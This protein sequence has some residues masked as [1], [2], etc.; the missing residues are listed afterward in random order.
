MGCAG[1]APPQ[2]KPKGRHEVSRDILQM[3]VGRSPS[4]PCWV[5]IMCVPAF[6]RVCVCV[7]ACVRSCVRVCVPACVC[8]FLHVCVPAFMHVCVPVCV[9]AFLRVCVPAFLRACEI[10]QMLH[11]KMLKHTVSVMLN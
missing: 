4:E 3:S 10:G 7:S 6:L 8:G 9:C 11:V 1:A 2:A 5:Q